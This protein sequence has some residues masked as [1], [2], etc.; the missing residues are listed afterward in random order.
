[1]YVDFEITILSETI[2]RTVLI[3]QSGNCDLLISDILDAIQANDYE[4][5]PFSI[6]G[7]GAY[8]NLTISWTEATI[9]ES[10]TVNVINAIASPSSFNNSIE[11]LSRQKNIQVDKRFEIGLSFWGE[12]TLEVTTD[13]GE[14]SSVDVG[15]A[16]DL[17][18]LSLRGL[19]IS[20]STAANKVAGRGILVDA[21]TKIYGFENDQLDNVVLFGSVSNISINTEKNT[22]T[23]NESGV[24]TGI[25]AGGEA[26]SFAGTTVAF[27]F[28]MSSEGNVFYAENVDAYLQSSDD[29]SFLEHFNGCV[30]LASGECIVNA[31]NRTIQIRAN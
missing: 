10:I 14:V 19:S 5:R 24:I 2:T 1:M 8:Q 16:Q 31:S 3:D 21:T 7:L 11:F 6:F 9:S 28:G 12:I 23:C 4:Q 29:S 26:I 17:N 27:P 18:Y 25:T 13:A 22:I 20:T 15:T 30:K